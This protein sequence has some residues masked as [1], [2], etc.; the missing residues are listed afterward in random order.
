MAART[1]KLPANADATRNAW[2]VEVETLA[3]V[4]ILQKS[5]LIDVPFLVTAVKF[6][7]NA[8][9]TEFAWIEGKRQD[10]SG[11]TFNDSSSGVKAQITAYMTE[12]GMDVATLDTWVDFPKGLVIPKGLRVSEYEVDVL[13]QRNQMETKTVKTH[14][15]TTSGQRA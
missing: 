10:G 7:I 11:F 9:Q 15:L 4:D 13:N 2:G 8:S 1:A 12:R 6:T 14:Y 5:E 3:G